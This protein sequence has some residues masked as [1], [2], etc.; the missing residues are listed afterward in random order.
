MSITKLKIEDLQSRFKRNNI[1]PDCFIIH[2]NKG[3]ELI[4]EPY[5]TNCFGICLVHSG[6]AKL[7]TGLVEHTVTAPAIIAMGPNVIRS[8]KGNKSSFISEVIFFT[9]DFLNKSATNNFNLQQYSYFDNEYEHTFKISEIDFIKYNSIIQLA[10]TTID[11][12]SKNKFNVVRNLISV[13]INDIDDLNDKKT[14]IKDLVHNNS[15]IISFK[16]LLADNFKKERSIKFYAE[17]LFTT[18]K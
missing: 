4:K 8:W 13:L 18:S 10:S 1:N 15:T 11:N 2:F 16:K 7:K 6:V 3:C 17:T 12:T 14:P 9:E 5:R